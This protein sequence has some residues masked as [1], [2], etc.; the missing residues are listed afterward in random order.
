MI[1][2]GRP[3]ERERKRR[4][5]DEDER[6]SVRRARHLRQPLPRLVRHLLQHT[7]E[8]RVEIRHALP[9]AEERGEHRGPESHRIGIDAERPEQRP[10]HLRHLRNRLG[11]GDRDARPKEGLVGNEHDRDAEERGEDVGDGDITAHVAEIAGRVDPLLAHPVVVGEH[12]DRAADAADER[13][14][15]W[16]AARR[17]RRAQPC[18]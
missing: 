3:R 18:R 4:E 13:Q 2:T 11:V 14:D 1:A 9:H 7:I 16:S 12:R 10:Q 6:D 15:A 17:D 8:V 5:R